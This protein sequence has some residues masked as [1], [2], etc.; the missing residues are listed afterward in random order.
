MKLLQSFSTVM[1][2][3]F[4]DLLHLKY[5]QMVA[6]EFTTNCREPDNGHRYFSSSWV[7]QQKGYNVSPGRYYNSLQAASRVDSGIVPYLLESKWECSE[8]VQNTKA[9][10]DGHR[11]CA[12]IEEKAQQPATW[13]AG[14]NKGDQLKTAASASTVRSWSEHVCAPALV[15]DFSSL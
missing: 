10:F 12:G 4:M 6:V 11:S 7:C 14:E 2:L 9:H 3:C 8:N 5:C 15:L 13:M 1:G